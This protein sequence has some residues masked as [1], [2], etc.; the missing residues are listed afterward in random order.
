MELLIDTGLYAAKCVVLI[1]ATRGRPFRGA[2]AKD[3][4][5]RCDQNEC[6]VAVRTPVR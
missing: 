5:H 1:R 3:L 6:E 4:S 2:C